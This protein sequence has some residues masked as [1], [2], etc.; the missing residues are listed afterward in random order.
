MSKQTNFDIFCRSV[1]NI[2][3]VSLQWHRYLRKS[4]RIG[5]KLANVEQTYRT[6]TVVSMRAII[7][8]PPVGVQPRVLFSTS[9]HSQSH[10]ISPSGEAADFASMRALEPFYYLHRSPLL[11]TRSK[12]TSKSLAIVQQ[13]HTV[14]LRCRACSRDKENRPGGEVM[15]RS[16]QMARRFSLPCLSHCTFKDNSAI[17]LSSHLP[18]D[19]PSHIDNRMGN[20]PENDRRERI[21]TAILFISEIC[22]IFRCL[23]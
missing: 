1:A 4:V 8:P 3:S 23:Y 12:G 19:L 6:L 2:C 20:V 7:E 18:H 9:Q 13:R 22:K 15:A 17:Y 16:S 11:D 10:S 21:G 5:K 14:N